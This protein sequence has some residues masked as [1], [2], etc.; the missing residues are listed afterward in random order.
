[1]NELLAALA[2]TTLG[3]VLA[4]VAAAWSFRSI[5][6]QAETDAARRERDLLRGLISEIGDCIGLAKEESATLL[7]VAYLH[8]A[9][10]LRLSMDT[11]QREVVDAYANAV[12]RYNGRVKR[13]VS[14][15]GGKRAAGESPGAEKISKHAPSVLS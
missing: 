4:F 15:G 10:P 5:R 2:G 14:F 13:L 12:L 6:R 11:P 7:P 9:M 1:V 3:G 8:D